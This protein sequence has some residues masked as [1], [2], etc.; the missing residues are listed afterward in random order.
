M[1]ARIPGVMRE[2]NRENNNG[3]Q[4]KSRADFRL[5]SSRWG[6]PEADDLPDITPYLI[7]KLG[8]SWNMKNLVDQSPISVIVSAVREHLDVMNPYFDILKDSQ[9]SWYQ[10]W[11]YI[12]KIAQE[13]DYA[14]ESPDNEKFFSV[15]DSLRLLELQAHGNLGKAD[16]DWEK[17]KINYTLEVD[18]R[19]AEIADIQK[20][21]DLI[22][23]A[24]DVSSLEKYEEKPASFSS[25]RKTGNPVCFSMFGSLFGCLNKREESVL[26]AAPQT[27]QQ[28]KDLRER[29]LVEYNNNLLFKT[30][31]LNEF[32]DMAPAKPTG[33]RQELNAVRAKILHQQIDYNRAQSKEVML[34]CVRLYVIAFRTYYLVYGDNPLAEEKPYAFASNVTIEKI[35]DDTDKV[36]GKAK[37]IFQQMIKGMKSHFSSLY[38]L[39]PDRCGFDKYLDNY[40]HIKQAEIR[41]AILAGHATDE[42]IDVIFP[43]FE[44]PDI[45]FRMPS[46]TP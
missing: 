28:L 34:H 4:N 16:S 1:D 14:A 15:S 35:Q 44:S 19:L 32:A 13:L 42:M 3:S 46:A 27:E 45:A 21:I 2:A 41:G 30:N 11:S 12:Y 17:A 8:D 23:A 25:E 36:A 5:P 43:D 20:N 22:K 37:D 6:D 39:Q 7:K 31:N 10:S 24:N 38:C 40:N 33:Y 9:E 18:R 29:L 26:P